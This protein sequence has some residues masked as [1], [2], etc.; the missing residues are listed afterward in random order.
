MSKTYSSILIHIIFS[1]YKRLRMIKI[2]FEERL[3]KYINTIAYSNN[4]RILAINSTE[5]HMHL[6]I[7]I[8]PNIEISKIIQIIKAKSSNWINDQ[9]YKNRKFKW[10][11]GYAAFSVSYSNKDSVINYIKK[12]KEH[13]KRINFEDEF[14]LF[15][16]RNNIKYNSKYIF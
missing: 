10:Q 12:Q 6:L 8:Y 2:D 13:H 4:I 1:T 14:K 3:F 11:N 9:F 5:D 16:E 7:S 15:L